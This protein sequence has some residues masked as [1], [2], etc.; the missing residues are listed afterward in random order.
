MNVNS[1]PET[2]THT[3]SPST[4]LSFQDENLASPPAHRTEEERGVPDLADPAHWPDSISDQL[5]MQLVKN[6]PV[7]G[8]EADYILDHKRRKFTNHHFTRT[9]ANGERIDRKWLIYST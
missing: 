9:M 7:Q 3:E 2:S 4:S 6:G 1:D 8:K 5:K